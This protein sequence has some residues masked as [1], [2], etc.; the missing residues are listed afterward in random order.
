MKYN[1]PHTSL[2]VLKSGHPGKAA[3]INLTWTLES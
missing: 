2:R 1:E 3:A